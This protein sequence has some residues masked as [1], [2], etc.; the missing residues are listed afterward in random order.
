MVL[1]TV[2]TDDWEMPGTQAIFNAAVR[3]AKPGAIILMHDAGGN[4]TETVQA[5]PKIINTLRKKG[6]KLVTVPR[7]LLDDPA[8]RQQDVASLQGAGG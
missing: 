2:D 7:L 6:Y 3:G 8:P 5:L 4:R 1:W